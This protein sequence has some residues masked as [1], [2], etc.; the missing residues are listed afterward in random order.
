MP[1]KIPGSWEPLQPP[2]FQLAPLESP[3]LEV[4]ALG[5]VR[6]A[7]FD[8][9]YASRSGASAQAREVYLAGCGLPERWRELRDGLRDELR[10]EHEQ[11]TVLELG[12]GL[13]VNFVE[14]VAAW[15]TDAT[16][17]SGRS[18]TLNYIGI[19]AFPVCAHEWG[20]VL[21]TFATPE[22]TG[23]YSLHQALA[24]QWPLPEPGIHY[25]EFAHEQGGEHGCVRLTLVFADVRQ[26]LAMLATQNI[27]ADA[28]YLDGFSPAKNPEMFAR[29]TLMALR[30]VLAPA[31]TLASYCVAGS[32]RRDMAA[33]GF[34]VERK[35]GFGTKR[36]RLQASFSGEF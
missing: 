12:F 15:Q 8:D 1:V 17:R 14:T 25:R 18:A 28:V 13:G 20:K 30:P 34:M 36:Q 16:Y 26:A 23:T 22:N 33:L 27:K 9:V 19:E 7:R 21:A 6:S 2:Q 31:A 11:F 4:D 35:P 10:G 29:D 3:Q 32:L 5:H 24:R